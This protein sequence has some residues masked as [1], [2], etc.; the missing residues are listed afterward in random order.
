VAFR[1]DANTTGLLYENRTSASSQYDIRDGILSGHT[2]SL[3]PASPSSRPAAATHAIAID[4]TAASQDHLL[5][6][7]D[8]D[9]AKNKR[10]LAEAEAKASAH[11]ESSR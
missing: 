2:N 5:A 1:A 10:M 6:A 4:R 7:A 9:V 11:F 3:S 8:D